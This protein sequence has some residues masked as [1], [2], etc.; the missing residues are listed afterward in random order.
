MG[1]YD[2]KR[3]SGELEKI[4]KSKRPN[5]TREGKIFYSKRLLLMICSTIIK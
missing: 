1:D 3:L 4:I 5:L 2:L